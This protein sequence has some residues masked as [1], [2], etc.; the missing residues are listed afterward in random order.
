MAMI[1]TM[2][3]QK[4]IQYCRQLNSNSVTKGVPNMTISETIDHRIVVR[5]EMFSKV[6]PALLTKYGMIV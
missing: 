3:P 1:S 6:A 4:Y 5:L 2:N